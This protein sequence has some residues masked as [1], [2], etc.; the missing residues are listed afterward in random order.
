MTTPLG[1]CE[2]PK[3]SKPKVALSMAT[4]VRPRPVFR[5]RFEGVNVYLHG[6]ASGPSSRKARALHGAFATR[7]VRLE[8]PDLTPGR[9]GFEHSTPLTMLGVAQGVLGST[10]GPHALIGSSLGGYLAAL[11]ASADPRI[12]RIVL[13]APAFRLFERW[14]ERLT[15]AQLGDW[16]DGGLE[17]DHHVTLDKRR[18]G[19]RFHEVAS[20][21]PGL[22]EVSIPALVI[23]GSRDETVPLADV[24]AWVERTPTARLVVVDDRHELTSSLGL[25]EREAFDFLRPL[26]RR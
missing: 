26:S 14:R 6:F 8:V 12:A 16:R 7:G 18:L 13:L 11:Q 15:A 23:A 3:V 25:I 22:P 10:P 5:G 1:R 24:E 21:L 2:W 20:G 9:A 19:W 4:H 17:V